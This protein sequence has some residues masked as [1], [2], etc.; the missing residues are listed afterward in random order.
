MPIPRV[1]TRA[2]VPQSMLT[3]R[4]TAVLSALFAG[5]PRR[6]EVKCDPAQAKGTSSLQRAVGRAGE[7]S[8]PGADQEPPQPQ[9]PRAQASLDRSAVVGPGGL[10]VAVNNSQAPSARCHSHHHRHRLLPALVA[11]STS[12][13]AAARTP[14]SWRSRPMIEQLLTHPLPCQTRRRGPGTRI[15]SA[16]AV[17]RSGGPPAAL[18]G[19][20]DAGGRSGRRRRGGP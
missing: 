10:K 19:A 11:L 12:T 17:P 8:Q 3:S 9:L 5:S 6:S 7:P 18:A 2:T 15:R 13:S 14:C 20:A 1:T 16:G 4:Q